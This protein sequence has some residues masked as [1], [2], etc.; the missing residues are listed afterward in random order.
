MVDIK[1]F[2]GYF[3]NHL[4][5]KLCGG[6]NDMTMLLLLLLLFDGFDGEDNNL[7]LLIFI[8]FLF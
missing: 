4:S 1:F 2:G 3:M 7:M 5:G 6:S 8:L